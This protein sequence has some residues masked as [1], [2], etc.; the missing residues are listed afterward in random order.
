MWARN[1]KMKTWKSCHFLNQCY[2]IKYARWWKF[3]NKEIVK[4]YIVKNLKYQKSLSRLSQE[5]KGK[6]HINVMQRKKNITHFGAKWFVLSARRSAD[7]FLL[8]VFWHFLDGYLF[9]RLRLCLAI[10]T[11]VMRMRAEDLDAFGLNCRVPNRIC[12]EWGLCTL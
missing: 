12:E 5:F 4:T 1:K 11:W 2:K 6:C 3:L 7:S 8:I 10:L 9:P